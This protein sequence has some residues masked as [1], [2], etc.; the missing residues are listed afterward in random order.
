[1]SRVVYKYGISFDEFSYLVPP[2][3]TVLQTDMFVKE[4]GIHFWM[5][6]IRPSDIEP[7]DLVSRTFRLFGTGHEIPD[8]WTHRGTVSGDVFVWHLYEKDQP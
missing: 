1:M 8:G 4:D 7:E 6:H 2:G 3:A 5:E